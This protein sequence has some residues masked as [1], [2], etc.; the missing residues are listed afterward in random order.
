MSYRNAKHLQETFKREL[1][2]DAGVWM[3]ERAQTLWD[4]GLPDEAA[5][6]YSE[7]GRGPALGK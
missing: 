6:L 1:W 7:F 2:S 4:G 5:A 3:Q